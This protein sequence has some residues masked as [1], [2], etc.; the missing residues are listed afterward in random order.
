MQTEA[1]EE[2]DAEMKEQDNKEHK[3]R[4]PLAGVKD[5]YELLGLGDVRWRATDEQIKAAYKVC[6]LSMK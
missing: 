6:L 1:E 2:E 3:K 5:Y 4:K